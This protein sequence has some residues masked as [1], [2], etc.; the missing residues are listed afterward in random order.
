VVRWHQ[1][2]LQLLGSAAGV[3]VI[4][5]LAYRVITVNATAV[6]FAYLL[7]VLVIASTWGF[8]EAAL[9]SLLATLAFNFF[10]LE[11][12]LTFTIADPQNWVAL[13]AFLATAL[14]AS[15][16]STKARRRASD[17]LEKQQDL[18]RLYTLGRAILLIDDGEPFSK[19]FARK[20]A[21]VFELSAVA[22]YEPRSGNTYR[23]GP[24]EF[25][26][27]DN[28]LREAALQGITYADPE[29]ER[30]ITAVRLGAQPIA[31][32][33]LQG[34]RMPDSVLQSVANLAAIGMERSKAQ[35][36]AHEAEV[37]RRSER[38]RTTLIDAMAHE[39][40]TPL[41]SIRAATTA[42]LASDNQSASAARMLKIADE[43]AA[44]LEGLIDEALDIA[45]LDSDRIHVERESLD[46]NELVREVI[47][48]ME[49]AIGERRL[50]FI[51]DDKA[52]PASL[53]R[54][55]MKIAIRQILDNALK[56]S[57]AHL[58]VTVRAFD[59]E[60]ALT[61]EITDHGKGI[62]ESEQARIFDRFFRSLSVR[63]K[64]PGSGLGLSIA[65]RI[66][67][68]HGGDLSVRSRPGETTFSLVVP[69]ESRQEEKR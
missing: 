9:A 42:L 39:L 15:R 7:F 53:D 27:I 30:V 54:K 12:R 11:P 13:F 25:E 38:L 44:R 4:T 31:S 3:G 21:E 33:A 14:I 60:G 29:L 69:L 51:P 62:S 66:L 67:H 63:D 49:T 52:P 68:A 5:W 56:Y 50:D 61:L 17:A 47:A 65:L 40:K 2:G 43:E 55:L 59:D 28:Q 1:R 20:L 26:G 57:P 22:V 35:D 41:T 16:L 45:Q 10:F 24:L 6:G 46:L 19:Q 8:P 48:S 23:G 37:A 34:R 18:E 36:L 64:I 58:P 32:L